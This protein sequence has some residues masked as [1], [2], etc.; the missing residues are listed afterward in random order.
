ERLEREREQAERLDVARVGLEAQLELLERAPRIVAAQIEPRELAVERVIVGLVPEQTL[1]DLDEV[2]L[3]RLPAQRLARDRELLD[4]VAV[5]LFLR[6]QLGELDA[7]R[8]V[9][10]VEVD[11]LLDRLERFLR[12]AFAM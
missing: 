6:V 2:V 10:G 4:G 8:D 3:T 1:G 11:E 12:V 5:E 9:V 7:R